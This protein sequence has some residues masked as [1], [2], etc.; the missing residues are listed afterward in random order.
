MPG[1]LLNECQEPFQI[2]RLDIA[3]LEILRCRRGL[4]GERV[5]P[6]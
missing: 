5:D 4:V 1:E 3:Q 2:R 6:L